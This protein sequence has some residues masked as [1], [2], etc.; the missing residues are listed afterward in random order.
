M[1]SGASSSPASESVSGSASPGEPDMRGGCYVR[2]DPDSNPEPAGRVHKAPPSSTHHRARGG[3]T[4]DQRV[5][6]AEARPCQVTSATPDMTTTPSTKPTNAS[7]RS[8]FGFTTAPGKAIDMPGATLRDRWCELTGS[9]GPVAINR[10]RRGGLS[11]AEPPL[12]KVRNNLTQK[13]MDLS[14]VERAGALF[15]TL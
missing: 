10:R 15:R 5:C 7:R 14:V 11:W 4:D 2:T 6:A 12:P 1:L 13:E 3:A 8:C 9:L